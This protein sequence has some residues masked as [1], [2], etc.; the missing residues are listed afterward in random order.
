MGYQV[1]QEEANTGFM[2]IVNFL[3]YGCFASALFL[4]IRDAFIWLA[5]L[6]Y[7]LA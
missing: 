7:N 1:V 6:F 2:R 5:G 4:F 3:S